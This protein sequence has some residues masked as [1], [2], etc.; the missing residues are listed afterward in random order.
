MSGFTEVKIE[1]TFA[2]AHRLRGHKGKCDN[3]HG[4]NYRIEIYARGQRLNDLGLLIDFSDLRKVA[5]EFVRYV[6]HRNLN[7]LPPFDDELNPSAEN[8]AMFVLEY[9]NSRIDDENV[10]VW[11][12]KCYES[13][14]SFAS[15]QIEN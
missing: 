2:A 10:K 9:M 8:I 4:H 12:V 13:E 14:T 3:L 15:Y 5:D 11:R 1:K 7:D 6:D